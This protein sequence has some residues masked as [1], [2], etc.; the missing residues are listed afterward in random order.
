LCPFD[1][2]RLRFRHVVSESSS[3]TRQ[4]EMRPAAGTPGLL[5]GPNRGRRQ[6]PTT[7]ASLQFRDRSTISAFEQLISKL[8]P[9]LIRYKH[10]S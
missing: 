1:L 10:L 2:N 6:R 7:G 4:R 5:R 3:Q 9:V 8:L